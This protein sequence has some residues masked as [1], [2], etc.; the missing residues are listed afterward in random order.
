MAQQQLNTGVTVNVE[1][2][3]S[4]TPLVFIHGMMLSGAFFKKQAPLGEGHRVV[5]PDLRGHGE[6]EKV[7]H[8]HTV[9]NYARDLKALLEMAGINRPVLIGWSMGVMVANEYL[10]QY[11]QDDVAG[12]VVCEQVPS[13]FAWPDY[14]YGF[15]TPE[16]LAQF[17]EMIQM[18]APAFAH[19]LTELMLHDPK[20]EDQKWME[21][22]ILK[23]PP[24]IASTVLVNQTIRDDRPFYPTVK[25]PTLVQFGRDPKLTNP[26]AAGYIASLVPGAKVEIF[27]NSSHCPF[28]EE[29]EAFNRSIS[30]FA[31]SLNP[32]G[33]R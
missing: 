30:R 23:V 5:I 19:E 24:A 27:E 32:A 6:S 15:F 14:K 21:A 33:V 31:Q 9:A 4:G 10:K 20:P 7:L 18:D 11:G 25:I 8:G 2:S 29:P 17:V 26:E 16:V 12:L 3:G 13:D 1:D 22:Q 28:W